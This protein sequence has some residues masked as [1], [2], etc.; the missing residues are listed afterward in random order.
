MIGM[1]TF[2]GLLAG[3]S[4]PC[5]ATERT[6]FGDCCEGDDRAKLQAGDGNHRNHGVFSTHGGN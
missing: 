6:V 5:Q 2:L 1:S 3:T 4:N